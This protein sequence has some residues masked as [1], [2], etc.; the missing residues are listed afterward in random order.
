MSTIGYVLNRVTGRSIPVKL[1]TS[2]PGFWRPTGAI[3]QMAKDIALVKTKTAFEAGNLFS[4]VDMQI[5]ESLDIRSAYWLRSGSPGRIGLCRSGMLTWSSNM[6]HESEGDPNAH[7]TVQGKGAGDSLVKD[8]HVAN[9]ASKQTVS[10]DPLHS[11]DA[12]DLC[13]SVPP[14]CCN[15]A[16]GDVLSWR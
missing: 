4:D 9:D 11:C 15:T 3:S 16:E 7:Y 6:T 12:A 14:R 1:T 10:Q 5:M 2:G 8:G 13:G